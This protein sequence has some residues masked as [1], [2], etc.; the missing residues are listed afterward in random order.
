MYPHSGRGGPLAVEISAPIDASIGLNMINV[1]LP[2]ADLK[3]E[4]MKKFILDYKRYSQKCSRKLL[5][6]MQQFI[7]E[8]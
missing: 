2:K 8:E 5:R 3:I 6:I 7:L 4:S 1:Q